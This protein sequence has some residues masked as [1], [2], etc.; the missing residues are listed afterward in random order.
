M[1]LFLTLL[2]MRL[3]SHCLDVDDL[4]RLGLVNREL[5]NYMSTSSFWEEEILRRN[6]YSSIHKPLFFPPDSLQG[7]HVYNS[8]WGP[9]SHWN[10]F[11]GESFIMDRSTIDFG[12][13]KKKKTMWPSW[14]WWSYWM[15]ATW[16]EPSSTSCFYIDNVPQVLRCTDCYYV[17]ITLDRLPEIDP[18]ELFPP[19]LSFG[20]CTDADYLWETD[21]MVGWTTQSI[22]FHTDERVVRWNDQPLRTMHGRALLPG[23]VLGCGCRRT[24]DEEEGEVFFTWNGCLI[25][26]KP[27]FWSSHK[28]V[29][30]VVMYDAEADFKYQT[31]FGHHAFRYSL[32]K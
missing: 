15:W 3:L 24:D 14:W 26:R 4:G 27:T 2:E 13:P 30:A 11:R 29:L 20:L 28:P 31:N 1:A 17:E 21:T 19:A 12:A 10:H 7:K 23:D 18:E 6:H 9:R 5:W 32:K 16:K 25:F 22:G 8:Y